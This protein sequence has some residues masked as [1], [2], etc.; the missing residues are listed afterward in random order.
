M[1]ELRAGVTTNAN[2]YVYGIGGVCGSVIVPQPSSAE[3]RFT[4]IVFG[5]TQ[6][7]FDVEAYNARLGPVN[8]AQL[9]S[10]Q[11]RLATLGQEVASGADQDVQL[12]DKVRTTLDEIALQWSTALYNEGR[13]SYQ[14]YTSTDFLNKIKQDGWLMLG[15][16]YME[17]A[18]VQDAVSRGVTTVPNGSTV[19][20]SMT[21]MGPSGMGVVTGTV[22]NVFRSLYSGYTGANVDAAIGRARYF[23][24][25]TTHAGGAVEEYADTNTNTWTAKIVSWFIND[26]NNIFGENIGANMDK[27]PVLMARNL[28][29]NMTMMGWGAYGIA[30]GTT[31][32]LTQSVAGAG[33]SGLSAM[34]SPMITALAGTI[35]VSGA[36][37][38]TYIPMLPYILWIGVALG[39]AVLLVEA[40]IA[41]PL[42]AVTHLAPDGDGVVGRGGQGYMLVLSLV[43]RPGLM[44]LGFASA[45]ILMDPLGLLINSTFMGAFINGVNP[46]IFGLS[47]MIMG[48][49]LYVVVMV[50]VITRV[51]A[52]IHIIPD[53]ILRWIGGGAADLG[54]TAHGI[55]SNTAAKVMAGA[56]VS[57]QLGGGM[58]TG[59]QNLRSNRLQQQQINEGKASGAAQELGNAQ[60]RLAQNQNEMEIGLDDARKST[61]PDGLKY[62]SRRVQQAQ[63]ANSVAAFGAATASARAASA[64]A[65]TPRATEEEK[66][67][68][69][70]ADQFLSA[71]REVNSFDVQ[72][73]QSF[74][75]RAQKT[76]A[77]SSTPWGNI[78]AKSNADRSYADATL[79]EIR[80]SF[81][82][83]KNQEAGRTPDPNQG[84][85]FN[86]DTGGGP[87]NDV[88]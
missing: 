9:A 34:L 39:W 68:G 42:W 16:W 44:V 70:Q 17:I 79:G 7:M 66:A 54:E 63:G 18:K 19:A 83:Q 73:T 65:S 26:D 43:L 23:A 4:G 45:V 32:A 14:S 21:G 6:Q 10:A 71:A 11:A 59:A 47:Q 30:A 8:A 15:A 60:D 3:G 58:L 27:N 22:R 46:S 86:Q 84:D 35:I 48:C 53:K 40:V 33:T 85:L 75:E 55:E 20:D 77:Y 51:F 80:G 61:T 28:G 52:L 88:R 41:A 56:Q 64:R 69:V 87:N 82:S 49:V 62:A 37:L 36:T 76:G 67:L 29:Q 24:S 5:S 2:G 72:A 78:M 31:V 25:R 38:S 13:A 57:G 12:G 50:S 1:D 74:M 81:Q